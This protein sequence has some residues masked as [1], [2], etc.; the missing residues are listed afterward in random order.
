MRTTPLPRTALR[1][2]ARLTAGALAVALLAGAAVYGASER[3][4]RARYAVPAHPIRVPDTPAAAARGAHLAATRGCVGCHGDGLA[5]R[6]ELD[7]PMVGRLAG[8]NLTRGG[9]GA[10]LTDADWERA[11]RHGVR[12]DG[13]PL[14]IM[15]AAEHTG[16]SDEDLGA[17]VAY[18][19]QLPASPAVPPPSRAGPVLR[20][21]QAAG[22]LHL[23]SA[24]EIDHR[25]PHPARV[26]P[27]PTAAYGAYLATMCTGCHGPGFSGGPI[28][29]A[30][31]AG[32]R[33]PTSPR[34][35]SATTPRP[36]SPAPCAS[37]GGPTAP[38]S[39][40]PC[41]GRVSRAAWTTSSCR[42]STP[43]CA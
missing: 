18:A 1:W 7:D 41:R 24:A 21:M 17:I 33:R 20:A 19:R 27:A 36:T 2:G 15:P 12:R 23:Y 5:G 8:P 39:T 38:P 6:V 11:V 16:M 34:P 3:H 40:Q 4:A 43:I 30:R 26:A 28:P 35:A 31:R 25:R 42:R 13:T 22:Q 32:S 14:F 9:R 37:A 10:A 29:G